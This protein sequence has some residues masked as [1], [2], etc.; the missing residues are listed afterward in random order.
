MSAISA[1]SSSSP[2]NHDDTTTNF[3]TCS[4]MKHR[5]NATFP[6]NTSFPS[7]RMS[8]GCLTTAINRLESFAFEWRN[9]IFGKCFSHASTFCML[10]NWLG[11]SIFRLLFEMNTKFNYIFC[12]CF[13]F[14]CIECLISSLSDWECIRMNTSHYLH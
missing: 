7:T 1:C 9:Q 2:R 12:V 10:N 6:K 5:R 14:A 4:G 11:K 3:R 8:Y 13:L